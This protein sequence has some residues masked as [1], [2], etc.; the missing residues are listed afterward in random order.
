MLLFDRAKLALE[1][2]DRTKLLYQ[3]LEQFQLADKLSQG[4]DATVY[5]NMG[6]IYEQMGNLP[7]ALGSYTKAGER[8]PEYFIALNNLALF[9]R[10]T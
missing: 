8:S 7:A 2:C 5:N 1:S 9:I 10:N 4:N 6:A 3:A